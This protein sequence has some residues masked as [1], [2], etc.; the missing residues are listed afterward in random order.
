M[1]FED[2][3]PPE[4]TCL[5]PLAAACGGSIDAMHVDVTPSQSPT[6]PA[7]AFCAIPDTAW[8]LPAAEERTSNLVT[9]TEV[10]TLGE[11]KAWRAYLD[12]WAVGLNRATQEGILPDDDFVHARTAAVFTSGVGSVPALIEAG[13]D[14]EAASRQAFAQAMQPVEHDLRRQVQQDKLRLAPPR[15]ETGAEATA[16]L[17]SFMTD[18]EGTSAAVLRRAFFAHAETVVG[19]AE[20]TQDGDAYPWLVRTRC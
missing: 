15:P 3:F 10:A 1:Q 14:V 17:L 5:L 19:P 13:R 12:A 11:R 7:F 2:T 6:L 16:R 20:P 18:S 8:A 9:I 4:P